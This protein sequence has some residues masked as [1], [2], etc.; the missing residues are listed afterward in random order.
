MRTFILYIV[1]LTLQL[2]SVNGQTRIFIDGPNRI[3][4]TK[5]PLVFVDT[6]KTDI[7]H[8]VLDPNKIVSI[9]I[10]KD[11][12]AISKYGDAA[13][14]GVIIIT[15]KTSATFLRVDKI[16]D[17]Y[18]LSNEDKKLRIC[19]NKTLMRDPQLILIENSEIEYVEV[20]TDRHWINIEDANSGE[21]F[22]NITT[23]TKPQNGLHD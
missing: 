15:P 8:L 23:K 20:T 16:F 21:K 5:K 17:N 18:K 14:F 10:L 19:I 2:N 9:N 12:T 6:F 13:K 1:S 3:N 4:E 22:I 11:S 7:N